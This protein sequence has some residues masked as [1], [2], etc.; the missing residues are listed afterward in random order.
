MKNFIIVKKFHYLIFFS[1]EKKFLEVIG[2]LTQ[3]TSLFCMF[4]QSS[5]CWNTPLALWSFIP[6]ISRVSYIAVNQSVNKSSCLHV[7]IYAF[8]IK[9]VKILSALCLFF[10]I[11][12]LPIVSNR[13]DLLKERVCRCNRK[14]FLCDWNSVDSALQYNKIKKIKI[15]EK[16][17]QGLLR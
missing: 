9:K 16:H 7:I 14:K 8:I 12:D 1:S 4:F 11:L 3:N 13:H 17:F 10:C 6:E 5:Q 15:V 2:L